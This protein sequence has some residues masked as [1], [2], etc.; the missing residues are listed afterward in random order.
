MSVDSAAVISAKVKIK[1]WERTFVS[2][3]MRVP[4]SADIKTAPDDV[5]G[6]SLVVLIH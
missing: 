3:N 5:R 2:V 1:E 6:Q 4:E